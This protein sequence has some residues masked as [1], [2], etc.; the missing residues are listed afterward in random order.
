MPADSIVSIPRPP[1][2]RPVRVRAGVVST[3][4]R[5]P[6]PAAAH[7]TS[8]TAV[9]RGPREAE[10]GRRLGCESRCVWGG[11]GGGEGQGAY[12]STG[13]PRRPQTPPLPLSAR[14]SAAPLPPHR[15]RRHTTARP[16]SKSVQRRASHAAAG[17]G[18]STGARAKQRGLAPHLPPP[19]ADAPA[20]AAAARAQAGGRRRQGRGTARRRRGAESAPGARRRIGRGARRANLQAPVRQAPYLVL[21]PHRRHLYFFLFC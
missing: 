1:H 21:R 11:E 3:A 9:Q 10:R 20:A 18:A 13:C 15:P 14:P 12:A 5:R 4:A 7:A 8:A 6:R 17:A 16:H 19:A 2:P